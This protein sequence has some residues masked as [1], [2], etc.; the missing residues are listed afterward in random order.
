MPK[1]PSEIDADVSIADVTIAYEPDFALK[2]L[3]GKDVD[4]TD[5]F[6]PEK[7][8]ACKKLVED[9]R[10]SFFVNAQSDLAK[11][12]KAI[13]TF[14]KSSLKEEAF[15]EEISCTVRNIKG[16]VELFGFILINKICVQLIECCKSS[17]EPL[18]TR[19]SLTKELVKALKLAVHNSITDDG[20][21]TGKALLSDLQHYN[22]KKKKKT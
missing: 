4:L 1:T 9:A 6:T 22:A 2:K 20:G 8:E 3:I 13:R 10:A 16:Q 7:I 14:T 5:I 19:F 17:S 21:E 11:L 15:F 18:S 12:E